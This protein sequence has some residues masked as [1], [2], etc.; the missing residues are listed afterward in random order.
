M[1]TSR[2]V[3]ICLIAGSL[4]SCD[5][6]SPT[7]T[8]DPVISDTEFAVTMNEKDLPFD[9]ITGPICGEHMR[10]VGMEHWVEKFVLTPSG[11][12]LASYHSNYN[13]TATGLTSGNVWKIVAGQLSNPQI[14][15]LTDLK[16]VVIQYKNDV[17]LVGQG[18]VPNI[19]GQWHWH[20]TVNANGIFVVA[21]G[22]ANDKCPG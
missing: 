5:N 8:A 9:F 1:D 16:P 13:G 4:A 20:L 22:F 18:S 14:A 2:V 3:L 19:R 7:E 21:R 17:V 12:V 6:S 15:D 10:F 11:R